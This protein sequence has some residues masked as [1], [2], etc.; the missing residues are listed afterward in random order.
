MAGTMILSEEEITLGPGKGRIQGLQTM[1]VMT[2]SPH[3]NY[4]NSLPHHY[5]P[6]H[7]H[8]ESELMVVVKG[9]M[10]FNGRWCGV[11]SLIYVPANEEYWYATADEGCM[12][13]LIRPSAPGT[14]QMGLESPATG[15]EIANHA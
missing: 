14:I 6:V 1:R 9:R 12:V 5:A 10:I 4:L 3:V 11:G 15:S 7:S 13:I 2:G 8:T